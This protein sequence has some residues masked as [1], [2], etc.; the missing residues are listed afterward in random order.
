MLARSRRCEKGLV[1]RTELVEVR[2]DSVRHRRPHNRERRLGGRSWD[3]SP[4]H[5]F[6]TRDEV[7]T[8]RGMNERGW[9]DLAGCGT[10]CKTG[11]CAGP[12][13]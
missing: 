5:G 9:G 2:R 6:P 4:T 12:S 11:W 1:R 8:L 10:H 3:A 7:R 13:R